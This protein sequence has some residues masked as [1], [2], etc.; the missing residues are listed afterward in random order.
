MVRVPCIGGPAGGKFVIVKTADDGTIPP[1]YS[2]AHFPEISLRDYIEMD[3][4][5]K[6]YEEKVKIYTYRLIPKNGKLWY[7]YEEDKNDSKT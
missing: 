1:Y 7:Q 5:Q 3:D 6:A 4:T 2:F